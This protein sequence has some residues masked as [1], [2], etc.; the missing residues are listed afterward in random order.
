MALRFM[1]YPHAKEA[2]QALREILARSPIFGGTAQAA[3]N[4]DGGRLAYLSFSANSSSG[5]VVSVDLPK[6]VSDVSD[7]SLVRANSAAKPIDVQLDK[8]AGASFARPTIGF[9]APVGRNGDALA[10]AMVISPGRLD[11]GAGID[12]AVQGQLDFRI[13]QKDVSGG[14]GR[15]SLILV[16]PGGPARSLDFRLSGFGRGAQIPAAGRF[17]E[18][19]IPPEQHD[20]ER[21]PAGVAGVFSP[22]RRRPSPMGRPRPSR[23]QPAWL[24]PLIFLSRSKIDLPLSSTGSR[25]SDRRAGF[26]CSLPIATNSPF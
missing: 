11:D 21:R 19:L 9:L 4:S 5:K 16:S 20:L 13:D 10:E 1:S 25:S 12:W 8:V 26:P 24:L 2:N 14:A 7:L 17:R 15:N 18:Q 23:T 3:L 6:S 22:S